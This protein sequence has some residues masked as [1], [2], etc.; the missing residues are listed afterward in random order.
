MF[1][2]HFNAV[3]DGHT[4]FSGTGVFK[5][6]QSSYTFREDDGHARITIIRVEGEDESHALTLKTTDESAVDGSNYKAGEYLVNM[7]KV[8]KTSQYLRVQAAISTYLDC[9]KI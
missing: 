4:F 1:A 5:L 3:L 8:S 6:S 9:I 7:T 2:S